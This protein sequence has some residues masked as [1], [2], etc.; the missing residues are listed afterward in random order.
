MF[1]SYLK[2]AFRNLLKH[3]L[4][5]LINIAGL[6]IGIA[7]FILIWLYILDEL[8]YDRYHKHADN[9][10][11][12]VNIYD[13]EGVGE[14]SASCPFPVA[15]TLKNE[16]PGMIKNVTRVFNRQ[17][18]RT[19]IRHG[20]KVFNERRF[21][22]ADSTFFEVFDYSFIKGDPAT[23]LDEIN[24]VVITESMAAKYFGDENPMGKTIRFENFLDLKV[25]GVIRDVPHNSHFL[26]DFMASLT[27]V[28]QLFG[29][30]MPSTW[31]WNPCWTYLLVEKGMAS[32][33][34]SEFTSF[35]QKYFYDAEKDNVSMYL[36]PLVDIHLKSRLDYE[37]EPNNNITYLRILGAIA[38]F[39]LIIA[40]I[41]YLNLATA[42]SAGRAG[43]ISVKKV[44]GALRTQLIYQFLFESLLVSFMA[45]VFSLVIIEILLPTLN[46]FSGKDLHLTLLLN[47]WYALAVLGI[48]LFT[49]LL[50]GFYPAFFLSSFDP[51]AIMKSRLIEVTRSGT[52]RRILVIF[53]FAISIILIIITLS[54][55]N[56]TKYLK[57][58]DTGFNPQDVVVLPVS[59][60]SISRNYETFKKE[61][62]QIPNVI[63]VTAFDDIPGVSH[64]THEFRPENFPEEKWQFFPALVVQYDFLKTLEIELVA[65]RDFQEKMKTDP[66]KAILI[67]ESMVRHIGWKSNEEAL[68][69]KFSSLNG[70]ERIIGVFRDFNVTSLHE[71]SGPFVL[72]LKENPNEIRFFLKYVGIRISPE[73]QRKTLA[74]IEEEWKQAGTDRPFEYFF[75]ENELEQLYKDEE[76]LGQLSFVLTAIIIFIAMLGLFGLAAFMAEKR[77][78][79]IG[80]R[81]VFGADES[82]LVSL[83]SREFLAL[84]AIATVIAWPVAY[85]L[86]DEWFHYFAH[87][88]GIHLMNFIWGALIA[89]VLAVI[90][91]VSRAYRAARTN[92]VEIIK[93]E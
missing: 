88:A 10:Y 72:N 47:P 26:F 41:N 51:V 1:I 15:W 69:K 17:V 80:I 5:T 61:L 86:I 7:S 59:G 42:T 78:K 71:P 21:F 20:D 11:R 48:G 85:L 65:G 68:G 8:S 66:Q 34:E 87:H 77:M 35:V 44:F 43:E 54:I 28:R 25:T 30:I 92:P 53:Q 27:T 31:V 52:A 58:A 56:Q 75:L 60:S 50:S 84:V 40:I 18:P 62:L 24:A 46:I 79:E 74:R 38:C 63:S 45:L 91:A 82:S 19:L 73:D 76:V 89:F 13:F 36:Q 67:N 4:Y 9:I 14:E 49:G 39:L 90:I 2:I 93:Y 12:L 33:L 3:R 32:S 16:Y 29:G 55:F 23:A 37:I 70:Q 83:L 81:K 57:N 64:N 6:A 22:F